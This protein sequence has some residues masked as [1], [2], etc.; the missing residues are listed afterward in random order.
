MRARVG[1]VEVLS[2][3]RLQSRLWLPKLTLASA[4][5]LTAFGVSAQSSPEA[6]LTPEFK[7]S[8]GLGAIGAQYAYA[9]G[10]TGLG[11][12]LGI[13]DSPIQLSH[14]EFAERI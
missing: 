2:P 13:A 8:W 10:Y 11:I 14:P 12:K 4:A 3:W 9:Q 7:A 1:C 6:F 5:A